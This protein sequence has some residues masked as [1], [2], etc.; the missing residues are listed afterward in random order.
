MLIA[1]VGCTREDRPK[2]DISSDSYPSRKDDFSQE[3]KFIRPIPKE[4]VRR[5]E[6]PVLED[7]DYCQPDKSPKYINSQQIQ[8]YM[9]AREIGL[10]QADAAYIAGFSERTGRRLEKGDRVGTFRQ[11]GRPSSIRTYETLI[12]QWLTESLAS[13][14]GQLKTSVVLA[15]L[16]AIGYKGSKSAVYDFVRQIRPPTDMYPVQGS[17]IDSIQWMQQLLQKRVVPFLK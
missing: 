12:Y 7:L 14:V 5:E 13:G 4:E 9:R 2:L 11:I 15:R 8:A 10:K 1:K 6:Q 17:Q 16:Q 3:N